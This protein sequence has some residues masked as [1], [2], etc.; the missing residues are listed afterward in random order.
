MKIVLFRDGR[1]GT[2]VSIPGD[3]VTAELTELLGGEI[4]FRA[5][6]RTLELVERKDGEEKQLP[7]RYALHQLGREPEPIAGDC[8]VAAA[9]PD[10]KLRDVSLRELDAALTYVRTVGDER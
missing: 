9:R 4:S 6:G 3:R 8:A 1:K 7:I 10:G 5:F 2:A